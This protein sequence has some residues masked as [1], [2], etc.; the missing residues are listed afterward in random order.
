MQEHHPHFRKKNRGWRRFYHE[1]L[2]F[3]SGQLSA[4][5]PVPKLPPYETLLTQPMMETYNLFCVDDRK[6]DQSC[7]TRHGWDATSQRHEIW[8]RGA[9]FCAFPRRCCTHKWRFL[10]AR[11]FFGRSLIRHV[12]TAYDDTAG[13]VPS[14]NWLWILDGGRELK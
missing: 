12:A 4:A 6:P 3:T 11:T 13:A 9:E 10:G 14:Y 1:W 8:A 2:A 5:H 7:P